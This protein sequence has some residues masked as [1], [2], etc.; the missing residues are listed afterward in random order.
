MG[1]KTILILNGKQ[2]QKN[3]KKV[4]NTLK[5]TKYVKKCRNAK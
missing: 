1:L 4:P 5:S 3:G 2:V